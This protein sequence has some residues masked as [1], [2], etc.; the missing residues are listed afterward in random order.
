MT[1]IKKLYNKYQEI[2]MYIIIGGLT[3]IVSLVSYYLLTFTI[4]DANNPIQLQIA[5]II[6]WI[7]CVSFAFF[8]NRKYVFK[9]KNKNRIK[10]CFNFF[11]ARL[12]TLVIDM[13]S[14]AV[15]VT[16]LKMDDSIAKIIVQFIILILNYV[17]SKFFVFDNK[18]ETNL[19][20]KI[21]DNKY[22]ILLFL[23]FALLCYFFPYSG[24]DWAWGTQIGIDRLNIWFDNYNGRYAGN[25][26]IL[27]ITRSKLLR[28]IIESLAFA[29]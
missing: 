16:C 11:L 4:L 19:F 23:L 27:A 3:T 22:Y 17:L 10:E 9:S 2:I 14:M 15:L 21:R 5:N 28:I 7:L 1:K 26:L 13:V 18:K 12:S 20:K 25:L 8:A 29:L 6:S 24:D